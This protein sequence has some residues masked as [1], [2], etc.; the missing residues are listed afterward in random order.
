[1]KKTSIV[2]ATLCTGAALA[3]MASVGT[4]KASSA[5]LFAE[6]SV[7]GISITLDKYCDAENVAQSESASGSAIQTV[8]TGATVTGT[9]VAETGNVTDAANAA[10]DTN[11]EDKATNVEADN[12]VSAVA[13]G[14]TVTGTAV[15]EESPYEN[16]GVSVAKEFVNIRKEPSVD[17]EIVGK[18]YTG[19]A[20]SILGYEGDWVKI[21]SG[22]CEGYINVEFLAVGDKVEKLVDTYGIKTATVTATTLKVRDD[23][24]QDASCV[25]LIPKGESYQVLEEDGAWVKISIDNGEVKGYVSKDY[26]DVKVEWNEAVSIAEE[27][28]KLR[29]EEEERKAA[30]AAKKAAAEAKAEE[31]RK[32]Q[33]Q[34]RSNSG[35]VSAGTNTKKTTTTTKSSSDSMTAKAA[36]KGEQVAAYALK[37]VGNPYVYGG[38]SLTKGTD[39]SG[40]TKSVYAHFGIK[41]NRVSRDQAKQ[42]KKV[43]VSNAKAGD[44]VFYSKGGRINHVA[45]CIGNGKVV[46]ASSPKYGIR[47]SNI[48]YRKVTCVRRVLK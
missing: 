24:S 12:T 6:S 1:M 45:L 35:S 19:A 2:K 23:K 36:S 18:L 29:K 3:I 21:K 30:E 14:S 10:T 31:T 47:T 22:S 43:S 9:S 38:T 5:T 44:L 20:A 15:Q 37:F 7:A 40:F 17:S 32:A 26:V 33:T 13:T 25:S 34:T 11:N 4:P 39:C 42:G 41:L 28:E 8:T 46:H 16:L 48:G 27:K